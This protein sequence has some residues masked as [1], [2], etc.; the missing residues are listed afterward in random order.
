MQH[1]RFTLIHPGKRKNKFWHIRGTVNGKTVEISTGTTDEI[2]GEEF[3]RR[4]EAQIR[5]G[6]DQKTFGAAAEAYLRWRNPSRQDGAHISRIAHIIGDRAIRGITQNDMAEAAEIL[7]PAHRYK[8]STRNRAVTRPFAAIM[9]YAA[10]IKWCEWL[11]VEAFPEP[12][13]ATRCVT[14]DHEQWLLWATHGDTDKRLMILWLFRQG[15]RISDALR[16]TY[17]DCDFKKMTVRR[18]VSKNS[19]WTTLPLDAAIGRLLRRRAARGAFGRIFRWGNRRSVNKWLS[20]EICRNLGIIFT[21]HM[22]RHTV[23]KRLSDAGASTRTVMGKLG[24]KSVKSALRY[25]AGDV[26]TIRAATNQTL[27]KSLGKRG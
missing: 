21:P 14:R 1:H 15:D 26:E 27:G 20:D 23:G 12:E 5:S 7:Y 13:H 3:A 4:Y 22:G 6:G 2:Q 18:F 10:R 11:R 9:H 17:E 24:Q 19:T 16:I 25:M 8:P